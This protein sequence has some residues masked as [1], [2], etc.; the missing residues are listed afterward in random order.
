MSASEISNA[1][2]DA[3][4]QYISTAQ[5]SHYFKKNKDGFYEPSSKWDPKS[6]PLD[7]EEMERG[8][9]ATVT[10]PYKAVKNALEQAPKNYEDEEMKILEFAIAKK[11][12]IDSMVATNDEDKSFLSKLICS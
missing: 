10:V 7:C 12:A 1:C 4:K 6:Q 2:Y 5:Q 11:I 9:L 8:M 3:K